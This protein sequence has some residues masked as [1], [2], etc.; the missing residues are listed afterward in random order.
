MIFPERVF[1]SAGDRQGG[2]RAG[3]GCCDQQS[4]G[5][6]VGHSH[7]DRDAG[8]HGDDAQQN[9]PDRER[10]Q[11]FARI[12]FTRQRARSQPDEHDECD[13]GEPAMDEVKQE[14]IVRERPEEPLR[15]V[16]QVVLPN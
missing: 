8:H 15:P 14:G 2:V 10:D 1:G 5:D 9:L 13:P 4:A 3:R 7:P 12:S 6:L 16:G 11:R